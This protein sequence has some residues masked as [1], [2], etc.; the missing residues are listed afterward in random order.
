MTP[1]E[2]EKE[3]SK[4]RPNWGIHIEIY[5]RIGRQKGW[6]DFLTEAQFNQTKSIIS[7]LSLFFFCVL[8]I[9]NSN[10]LSWRTT[11]HESWLCIA[12]VR[13]M[14]A[15]TKRRKR[16][17]ESR[18]TH[19]QDPIQNVIREN[20]VVEN[21]FSP[22]PLLQNPLTWRQKRTVDNRRTKKDGAI[23]SGKRRVYWVESSG[24]IMTGKKTSSSPIE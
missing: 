16:S 21:V 14:R 4:S 22:F 12:P 5:S 2:K 6:Q 15:S 19:A 10:C 11:R 13:K 20:F 1:G 7:E 8:E 18:A 23:K 9:L 3:K 24:W 17:E